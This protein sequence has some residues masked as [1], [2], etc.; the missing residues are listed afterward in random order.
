MNNQRLVTA[1]MLE[2]LPE[3]AQRYMNYTGVVGQPWI[4]TI[5]IKYAGQFRRGVDQ[6]WLP[7][8][9]T[10]VYTTNPPAF[11][12][13]ARLKMFGLWL[14]RGGDTYQNGHGHMF[15]KVAGVFTIF[16]A[17][18]PEID[19]GTRM[20]YLNEMTWFPIALLSDYITW[21]AVD[22]QA[23]DV[24]YTDHGQSVTARFFIA[25][26]G[27]LINFSAMRYREHKGAYTYDRW[28][29]PMTEWGQLGGL[30]LPICG[31]AVW[32]LPGGDLPYVDIKLTKIV[33]NEPVEI[34][35]Q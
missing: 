23:F 2:Q 12:W 30:N 35:K 5:R 34:S 33:Y 25:P 3:P 22:D 21:Q 26:D 4:D 32:K 20:R 7:I 31:Q 9:A 11:H 14:M 18:G 27:R 24:T 28:D 15:G 16:D 19:Q 8:E 10:Q 1:E 6:P 29:T 13:N 17:R